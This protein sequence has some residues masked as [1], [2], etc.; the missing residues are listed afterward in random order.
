MRE[1]FKEL[2]A[3]LQD[4]SASSAP[5]NQQVS[6]QAPTNTVEPS[7]QESDGVEAQAEPR[8]E[9][10]A[11][12][13]YHLGEYHAIPALNELIMTLWPRIETFVQD[14]VRDTIEP[15]INEALP[16]V[17]TKGG[18][19]KF[20]KVLL[21]PST[22]M[23]G[24]LSVDCNKENG[25]IVLDM[26]VNMSCDLDVELTALHIP[27]GITKFVLKGDLVI[28]LSPPM[29]KPP[30][31]G[32]IQVYFLNPPDVDI[33]FAKAARVAD[34]PGLRGAVRG[35][36]DSTISSICVIP[37]RIAV[38][39]NEDD[40]VDLIDLTYP[41]PVGILRFTLWSASDL[42]AA[43]IGVFHAASS[44]PYVVA[45]L[46]IKT[47]T[48]PTIKKDLN[49]VWGDGNGITTD[50]LVHDDYQKLS[51]KVYDYDFGTSDDLIGVSG[52]QALHELVKDSAPQSVDLL[53][54]NGEP[55]GGTLTIS[56]SLL[57]LTSQ[58]PEKPLATPGP[59]E[60][61]LSARLLTIKGLQLGAAY[62]FKVRVQVVREEEG[63]GHR[64]FKQR[65]LNSFGIGSANASSTDH[66]FVEDCTQASH[67]K[68]QT[69]LAEAYKGIATNLSEKGSNAKDIAEILEVSVPEVKRFLEAEQA[70]DDQ[71]KKKKVQERRRAELE[72]ASAIKPRFD[73]VLEM[74][75]PNEA[76]QEPCVVVLTIRDKHQKLLGTAKVPMGELL[77]APNFQLEGAF[78]TDA[79]GVDVVGRLRL[80]WL[81]T[82]QGSFWTT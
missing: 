40:D 62:S 30:F 82:H 22:P 28:L 38:D 80:R 36:I 66:V 77:T 34:I 10:F 31:V 18:G 1:S 79:D 58:R 67:P 25:D 8:S 76:V 75:L 69:E 61:Y 11:T 13:E 23:L 5:E 2:E 70:E 37:R 48:S 57:K 15:S 73:E 12:A 44:D 9:R 45:S 7:V 4:D 29:T 3:S 21:G 55:G 46:G 6:E 49:P 20:T 63:E 26:V 42:I 78:G 65:V 59:S 35:A 52:H 56:T 33:G 16:G 17:V 74:M 53:K 39:M 51:L 41:E 54:N 60:A 14:L 47:W 32:G 27:I 81:R 24:P 19:V 43:D 71:D 50:F 72:R 68:E 64:S